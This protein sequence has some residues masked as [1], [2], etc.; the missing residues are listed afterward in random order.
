MITIYTFRMDQGHCLS[1]VELLLVESLQ[2]HPSQSCLMI[3]IVARH[4]IQTL[5]EF[6]DS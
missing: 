5:N 3:I 2:P 6:K 1:K 4:D